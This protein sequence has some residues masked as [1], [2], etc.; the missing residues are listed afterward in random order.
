MLP[1]L[2]VYMRW[3]SGGCGVGVGDLFGV[4]GLP[5]MCAWAMVA[6]GQGDGVGV[7]GRQWVLMLQLLCSTLLT[8]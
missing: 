4:C 6:V 1:A 5:D 3:M 7:L 2:A 8:S